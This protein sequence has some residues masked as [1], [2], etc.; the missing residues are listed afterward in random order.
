S[1]KPYDASPSDYH[2]GRPSSSL[3]AVNAECD[4]IDIPVNLRY[5]FYRK[6]AN[7]AGLTAGLSSYLMLSE[8]YRYRYQDYD[9]RLYEY[10]NEN[11]HFMGVANAGI[12]F[13]RELNSKMSIGLQPF[14]K[15]PLTG[16][17]HGKVKLIS[18]GAAVRLNMRLGQN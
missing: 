16:I 7:R 9:S 5:D 12:V 13:E 1:R 17:G 14:I 4:V 2:L 10:R 15:I 11:Q 6:G 3:L 8:R 18:T